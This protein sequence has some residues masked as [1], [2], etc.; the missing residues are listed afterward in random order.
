VLTEPGVMYGSLAYVLVLLSFVCVGSSA[1]AQVD[2]TPPAGYQSVVDE[3]IAEFSAAN[4][5]ESLAL[6]QQAQQ[7]WPSARSARAIARC[8]YELGDYVAAMEA[9]SAALETRVRPL[10]ASQRAET[11]RLVTRIRE[12]VARF[13]IVT[14]PTTAKLRIDGAP[15]TVD[16]DGALF[17]TLGT[18]TFE[19][20]A[21]GY[22]P[23]QRDVQAGPNQDERIELTLSPL[24]AREEAS[25]AAEPY[26]STDAPTDGDRPLRKKWWLW[27]SIAGAVA[28]AAVATALIVTREPPDPERPSGGTSGVAIGVPSAAA[29]P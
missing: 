3:A 19:A 28:V 1:R 26:R 11:E 9:A 14:E 22:M 18:H 25:E 15:A 21:T 10:D 4:Y 16:A 8:H 20:S 29:N 24:V 23:A 2:A 12:H 17:V 5:P 6:F 27:T 7:L 13:T